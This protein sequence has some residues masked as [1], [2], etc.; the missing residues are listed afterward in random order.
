M[1]TVRARGA[2]AIDRLGHGADR[3]LPV[4]RQ[5]VGQDQQ[6]QRQV[7]VERGDRDDRLRVE[8]RSS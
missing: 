6:I 2:D 3:V 4:D 7:L 1:S 5:R 8:R